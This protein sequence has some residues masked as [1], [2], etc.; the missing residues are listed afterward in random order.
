M[1]ANSPSALFASL[2]LHGA[3]AA[4]ILLLAILFS[5]QPPP[6][7]VIFELVAGMPTDATERGPAAPDDLR[8]NVP[9]VKLP[10]EPRVEPPPEPKEEPRPEEKV[11]P[12]EPQVKKAPPKE[13]PKVTP[14]NETTSYEEF[15]KKNPT[16]KTQPT[17]Q[18]RP[19]KSPQI[20]TTK[21]VAGAKNVS[22]ERGRADARAEADAM[23]VYLATLRDRLREA[24]ERTKPAGLGDAVSAEVSFFLAANGQIDN[25]RI[26]RSSGFPEFDQSVLEAFRRITW[27]GPRPDK[28]NE[29]V[30]LTFRMREQ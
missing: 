22:G 6:P 29:T 8:L 13:Q 9:K 16:P 17:P 2:A 10:P 19:V 18:A 15:R 21:I 26:V 4:A 12:K 28:R 5:R 27:P 24:H 3:M 11:V 25:V 7:P 20:D 14:K 1:R 30:R 23:T